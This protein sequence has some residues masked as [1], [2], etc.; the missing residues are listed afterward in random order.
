MPYKP[1]RPAGGFK[2][3]YEYAN[4]LSLLGY[5][6]HLT[7]PLKTQ[8]MKDK[9]PYIVRYI[10]SYI[11]GFRTN[12]WFKFEPG[13]TMSYVPSIKE[14]YVAD[15]DIVFVT[16]WATVLEVGRLSGRKGK[17]INLIQGYEN[18]EGHEELLLSSYNI[19]DTVN[20]VVAGYLKD[21]VL[22]HTS[23]KTVV[24]P[25][26]VDNHIFCIRE[27]IEK[28]NPYSVCMVYSIQEIKGSKY[29]L[30]ALVKVKEKFPE[31]RVELFGICAGPE[32]LPEWITF[33]REPSDL[34]GLYNRNAIFVSNSFTEGFGLVSVE[35]MSCGCALVCTDISGHQEYAK[36]GE[37]AL[38]VQPKNAVQMAE[39]ICYLIENNNARIELANRG[40][41]YVKRFSWDSTIRMV[42]SLIK[43]TLIKQ[44]GL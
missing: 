2:I 15:A 25:N 10:L 14:Q 34:P 24:I 40:N 37:T 22:K 42:D 26:A 28:R 19:P 5:R 43:E 33:F 36:E 27:N 38:L 4:R 32:N 30:E 6:V 1:R 44:P 41:Q 21:I 11:E 7:Y 29:G 13:I 8:F 3:M 18:W 35:A 16:W 20:I 9:F 23:N 39:K 31:L 12:K 17:K